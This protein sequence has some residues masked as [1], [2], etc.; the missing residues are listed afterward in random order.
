M[1]DTRVVLQT[2]CLFVFWPPLCLY[3]ISD[4]HQNFRSQLILTTV[5]IAEP[6]WRQ[7]FLCVAVVRVF[8]SLLVRRVE[9]LCMGPVKNRPAVLH[10]FRNECSARSA[11]DCRANALLFVPLPWKDN[12]AYESGPIL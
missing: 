11:T 10:R 12:N 7:Q 3:V 4:L 2:L 5:F 1:S 6:E 8:V 9:A